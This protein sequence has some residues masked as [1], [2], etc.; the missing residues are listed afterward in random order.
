[1]KFIIYNFERHQWWLES[2]RGYTGNM[3]EAGQFD[4]DQAAAIIDQAN[5]VERE[6]IAIPV[7]RVYFDSGADLRSYANLMSPEHPPINVGFAN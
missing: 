2:M 6:D 3:N 1:M 5:V 4:A 7:N